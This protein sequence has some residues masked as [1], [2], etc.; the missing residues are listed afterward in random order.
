VKDFTFQNKV[1]N[2]NGNSQVAMS[3][4]DRLASQS[5]R[6]LT[7]EESLKMNIESND[8]VQLSNEKRPGES[9]GILPQNEPDRDLN[10]E[11]LS[12]H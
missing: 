10:K 2:S 4:N 7:H 6:G 1:E 3:S 11:Q 12:E 8:Q 9:I 5:L